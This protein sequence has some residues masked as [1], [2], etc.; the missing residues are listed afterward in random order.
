MTTIVEISS[1]LNGFELDFN[2]EDTIND[3]TFEKKF[4]SEFLM[5]L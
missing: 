3:V 2:F 4:L 1:K 5:I